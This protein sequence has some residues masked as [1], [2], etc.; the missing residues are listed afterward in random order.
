MKTKKCTLVMTN[1]YSNETKYG[2]SLWNVKCT[3]CHRTSVVE[4]YEEQRLSTT[5]D[6]TDLRTTIYAKFCPQ[7]GR[8][9][10]DA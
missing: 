8:E 2:R 9:V 5:P 7:C 6:G 10:G 4:V 3:A 1:R